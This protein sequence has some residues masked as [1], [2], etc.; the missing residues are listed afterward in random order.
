[1]HASVCAC[2]WRPKEAECL[3][4]SRPYVLRQAL[5]LSPH[6]ALPANVAAQL[7]LRNPSATLTRW[8]HR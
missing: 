4:P 1:M 2:V 5:S 7:T 6:F 8:G 3:P